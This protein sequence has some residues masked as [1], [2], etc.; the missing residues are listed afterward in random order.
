MDDIFRWSVKRLLIAQVE[1]E[2]EGTHRLHTTQALK[3]KNVNSLVLE[4]NSPK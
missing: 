3:K 2:K 4:K 1:G